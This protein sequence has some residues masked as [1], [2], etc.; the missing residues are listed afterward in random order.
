MVKIAATTSI[1]ASKNSPK[2]FC[3]PRE[4]LPRHLV[5]WGGTL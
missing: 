2:C 3:I 5:S 1:F 4:G